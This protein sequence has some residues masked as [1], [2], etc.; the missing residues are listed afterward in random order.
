MESQ[1]KNRSDSIDIKTDQLKTDQLKT[2]QLAYS[3]HSKQE[4]KYTD[5]ILEQ[6]QERIKMINSSK[7]VNSSSC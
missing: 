5:L 4:K 6:T 2:D 3:I 1:Q 7:L